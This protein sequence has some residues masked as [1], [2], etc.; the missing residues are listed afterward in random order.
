[1]SSFIVVGY[2]GLSSRRRLRSDVTR[3]DG[4]TAAIWHV[5]YDTCLMCSGSPT[6]P[7]ELR[8]YSTVNDAILVD[9]TVAF[10]VAKAFIPPGN[11]PGNVLLDAFHVVPMSGDPSSEDYEAHLP[12]FPLHL[13]FALGT[14]TAP[15]ETLPGGMVTFPLLLSEYVRGSMRESILQYVFVFIFTRCF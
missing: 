7:A 15:H 3:A 11:L 2:F 13:V 8:K 12:D 14:V 4:S 5:Y 9:D 6:L 1:M 10:V